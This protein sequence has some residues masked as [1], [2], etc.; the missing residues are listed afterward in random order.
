[1][2]ITVPSILAVVIFLTSC[3]SANI[4]HNLDQVTNNHSARHKPWRGGDFTSP[5]HPE[6]YRGF[7]EKCLD[8]ELEEIIGRLKSLLSW[9]SFNIAQFQLLH[10]SIEDGIDDILAVL[11]NS[12][13]LHNTLIAKFG[14]LQKMFRMMHHAAALMDFYNSQY[15]L[16]QAL[17]YKTVQLNVQLLIL[18]DSLGQPNIL[19]P[20]FDRIVTR[21]KMSLDFWG[22]VFGNVTTHLHGLSLL[23]A[24]EYVTAYETLSILEG[25]VKE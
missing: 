8:A 24:S 1:M 9:E 21:V 17:L 7:F 22:E 18:D 23:F 20:E 12:S 15:T 6:P 11:N 13:Q 2:H 4:A 19:Y 25:H 10:R 16:E 14:Y 5:T 3:V